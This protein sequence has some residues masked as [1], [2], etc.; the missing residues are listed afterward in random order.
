MRTSRPVLA[1]PAAVVLLWT[2]TACG[3]P[4]T[5]SGAPAATG[6]A[7]ATPTAEPTPEVP[8]LTAE[9]FVRT[10]VDAQAAAGSFEFTMT[11]TGGASESVE[12]S[13]TVHLGD[14]DARATAMT[15]TLPGAEPFE[16]R[17][18]GGLTYLRFGELTG[19][20]FLELDPA[21]TSNPFAADL[22][23]M[24]GELD[25]TQE[26]AEHE[27]SVVS[28]TKSGAPEQLDG[29]EVQAYDLVIDP[30]KLPEQLA[31]LEASLPAGAAVPETLTYQYWVDASGLARRLRFEIMGA[32]AE[33]TFTSWGTAA[34]VVAPAADEISTENPFAG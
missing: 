12:S 11:M 24:D 9:N 6:S 21:D 34:P 14:A 23:S 18:T 19:D 1:V 7:A 32:K 4:A 17:T 5:G 16:I 31:E 20:K 3:S 2:L 22:A 33:M 27:G 10:V 15:T 26:L 29:V 25:P 28:V 13:G 8:E 30:S